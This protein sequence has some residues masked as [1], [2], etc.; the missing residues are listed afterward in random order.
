[1]DRLWTD[2]ELKVRHSPTQPLVRC[3]VSFISKSTR[4]LTSSRTPAAASLLPTPPRNTA[5]HPPPPRPTRATTAAVPIRRAAAPSRSCRIIPTQYA[6]SLPC[7]LLWSPSRLRDQACRPAGRQ[8]SYR[9]FI[10]PKCY[11]SRL[12]AALCPYT[13]V[14]FSSLGYH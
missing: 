10:L 11:L 5:H 9:Q 8:R 14:A 7:L 6:V 12:L 2:G 13:A 4:H 3:S 1:M